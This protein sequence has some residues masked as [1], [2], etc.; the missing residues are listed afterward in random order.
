VIV[1]P[2]MLTY[3][4]INIYFWGNTILKKISVTFLLAVI[5]AVIIMGEK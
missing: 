5:V 1:L 3:H 4:F 2:W